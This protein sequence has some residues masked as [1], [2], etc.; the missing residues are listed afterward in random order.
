MTI[1][2]KESLRNARADL[3][4][5]ER[6]AGAA[7]GFLRGYDGARPATGGAAT[8]LLFELQFSATSA[9]N[10]VAG[11]VTANAITG[12]L[13]ANATGTA[14]WFREVDSDGNFVLDGDVGISGADLNLNDV[15]IVS[16]LPVNITSHV[17][18][19]GNP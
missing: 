8:T 2:M 7:G 13:S 17:Y 5:A 6:D 16:G 11:V 3:I 15:N 9:P 19:E 12:D 14:T 18:T 4:T 1:G 10:A